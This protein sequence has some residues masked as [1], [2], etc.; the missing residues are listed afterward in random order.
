MKYSIRGSAVESQYV[1]NDVYAFTHD[2][3][4]TDINITL[5]FTQADEQYG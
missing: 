5:V 1:S 4:K 2:I 3:I